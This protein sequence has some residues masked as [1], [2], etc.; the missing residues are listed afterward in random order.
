MSITSALSAAL[1][2]I[3]AGNR[4]SAAVANNIANAT[5]PGYGART[6]Q[7]ASQVASGP[8][9]GGVR[10]T[11]V[12]RAADPVLIAERRLADA[13]LGRSGTAAAFYTRL[14]GLIG[15]PDAGDSL[16]A[17]LDAFETSLVV[18]ANSPESDAALSGVVFAADRVAGKLNTISDGIQRAR[19][20]ADADINVAVDQLNA[21]L[22][23]LEKLNDQIVRARGTGGDTNSLL[24]AQQ[25]LVDGLSDLVPVREL[26]DQLG[27]L[28][29]YS[30][31]GIALLDG[32]AATF[33][34][35]PTPIITPDMAV[36]GALSAL[37]VNGAPIPPNGAEPG[38][39][40]GRL[41][42]L[43]AVRD[44]LAVNAQTK[45][46]AVARDLAE[47]FE[48][49]GLDP[50]RG[51]TDPGLFTDQGAL[52][53]PLAEEGLAQRI[54]LNALV[55]PDR[56]GAVFRLRDG[57]GA[58]APAATVGDATLLQGM[59]AALKDARPTV[60][61]GYSAAGRS[62]TVLSAEFLS[63]FAGERQFSAS[64]ETF[65][66][67]RRDTLQQAELAN[68]VNT[69]AELQRLILIE[70]LFQ[71]NARVIQVAG[72]MMDEILRSIR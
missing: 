23:E 5:T 32:R 34:F 49:P 9:G 11:G 52:T 72:N 54:T 57:L 27:R 21:S 59:S 38:L 22:V 17:T 45:L 61:G 47:R 6:V 69:D 20:E 15:T 19:A 51:P 35:D 10:V 56:G 37:T 18:A 2:G 39:T 60:S 30:A 68:G 50:T 7:T 43:F 31:D 26:R 3:A 16:G 71:A 70:D 29:L 46:D 62:I 55:D 33:G 28:R 67:A 48:A 53:D 65:A 58:A 25:R 42:A 44:D 24:D 63:I 40:G 41:G 8:S 13:D 36:G 4:K 12:D 64:A 14:E 66:V 1:S